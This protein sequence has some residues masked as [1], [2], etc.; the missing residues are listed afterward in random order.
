MPYERIADADDLPHTEW[1]CYAC[2]YMNSCLDAECQNTNCITEEYKI[3][4][5]MIK[6]HKSIFGD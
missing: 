4:A 2:G 6:D 1:K 5:R 3:Y